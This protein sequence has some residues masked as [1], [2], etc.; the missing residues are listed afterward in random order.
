M[1]FYQIL[2]EI[3]DEKGIGIADVAHAC[4]L[5]DSTVRSIFD[6]HQKKIA[7]NVAFKLSRGL[8]V[9]LQRLNG[10]PEPDDV[11]VAF[12]AKDEAES[13]RAM[14]LLDSFKSLN[15]EGQ[16][17]LLDLADDLVSSGKYKKHSENHIREKE[18]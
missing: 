5:R 1:D 4:N 3:M 8:N 2:G 13:L 10:M 6:R 15:I 14:S 16:E 17:K 9:S 12:V 11:S 18:A 7:L